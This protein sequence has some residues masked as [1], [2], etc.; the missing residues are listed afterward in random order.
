MI[1]TVDT[2]GTK[3]LFAVYD[4]H[5]VAVHEERI[6]TPG[7]SAEYLSALKAL[8]EEIAKE[9]K[10]EIISIGIPGMIEDNIVKWAGGNLMWEDLDIAD[11]LKPAFPKIPI[12]IEN[13]ANLA[14]LAEAQLIKPIA[15]QALYVTI[16]T[17]IGT[18]I[19]T[20]GALE[21]SLKASEG[22]HIL[23][24]YDG[25]MRRWEEF[26]SGKAIYKTYGKY[27]RDIHNKRHWYQIADRISRGFLV[28]IPLLQPNVI[29]IGGS[30]GTYFDRFQADL[31]KILDE[32]LA[33]HIKR[34]VF[35]QAQQPEHA[36][37]NGAHLN[38]EA[39]LASNK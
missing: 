14:G 33:S 27:A 23:L 28:I 9:Y 7:D 31:E 22:G 38:A 32:R 18:A 34:P 37:I 3:T 36:V 21:E 19:V 5:G 13:D 2:G 4:K 8:L 26:A 29:I 11:Y 15:S 30:I 17:G 24:E 6:E 16:S 25:A 1:I 20:N 12:I 10:P 35:V 39:Y